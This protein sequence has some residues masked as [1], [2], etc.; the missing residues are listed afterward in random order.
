MMQWMS[1]PWLSCVSSNC[2]ARAKVLRDSIKQTDH[3]PKSC[4]P[5]MFGSLGL[6]GFWYISLQDESTNGIVC[7]TLQDP[8]EP[9]G[10]SCGW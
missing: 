3:S 2:C 6:S 7:G 4:W 8:Q 9:G 1:R 5:L 10:Q